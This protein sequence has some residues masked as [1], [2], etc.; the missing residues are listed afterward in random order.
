MLD[1]TVKTDSFVWRGSIVVAAAALLAACATAP[2][3]KTAALDASAAQPLQRLDVRPDKSESDLITNLLA[4]E[5]ALTD[6]DPQTA[7]QRYVDAAQGSDD[8]AIAEQATHI[9]IA[10]RH[11]TPCTSA[12]RSSL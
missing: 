10:S 7:A 6:A 12:P 11:A 8:P 9:A 4:G 5:L 3:G 2:A 1:E